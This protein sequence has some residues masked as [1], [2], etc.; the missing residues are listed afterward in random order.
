[1]NRLP[2]TKVQKSAGVPPPAWLIPSAAEEA[3]HILHTTRRFQ[4]G[5]GEFHD[6]QVLKLLSGEIY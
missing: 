3:I 4:R 5:L 6:K 1:M 2:I